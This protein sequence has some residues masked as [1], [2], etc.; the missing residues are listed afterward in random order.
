MLSILMASGVLA[1]LAVGF[2][3]MAMIY[4][5][6]RIS[7]AHY[8]PA[9]SFV[10]LLQNRITRD[11]FPLYVVAQ[12]IGAALASVISGFLLTAVATMDTGVRTNHTIAALVAEFVGTFALAYVFLNV[13][14]PKRVVGNMYY[15]AAIGLTVT[16]LGVM[17]EGVSGA[18]FNPAVALGMAISGKI[19]WGDVWLYLVA[20][21]LGAGA[22]STVFTL[23]E[24]Q[25][26]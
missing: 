6:M 23:L 17:L 9:I 15:G 24:A 8:N 5:G 4:S 26:D 22:A 16:A 25:E 2:L 19:A 18:I 11:E 7:G 14:L 13:T 20:A 21:F 12:V 10:M 3:L 1:P